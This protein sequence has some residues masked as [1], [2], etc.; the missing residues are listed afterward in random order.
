M[1]RVGFDT[2]IFVRGLI[3]PHSFAGKLMFEY[4]DRYQLILSEPIV[5]EILEVLQRPGLTR[6]Y[7]ALRQIM[8]QEILKLIERAELVDLS[9]VRAVSRDPKDDKFL[10]TAKEGGASYIVSADKDLLNWKSYEG[11]QIVEIQTFLAV[12]KGGV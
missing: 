2:V 10:A 5:I 4:A 1:V 7:K 9:S 11:I 12:V 8:P 6:K 3:N